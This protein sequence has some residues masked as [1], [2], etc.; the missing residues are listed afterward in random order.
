MVAT[1]LN[2]QHIFVDVSS[3]ETLAITAERLASVVKPGD[4]IALDGNLGA[5][6]TTF[7]QAFGD[8]LGIQEKIVSPTFVLIHEYELGPTPLIHI[9]LYRLG[10]E[11]ADSLADD[12]ATYQAEARSVICVEWAHLSQAL[13]PLVT[14]FISIAVEQLDA[15]EGTVNCCDNQAH[16]H[17]DASQETRMM[18]I[19]TTSEAVINAFQ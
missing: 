9:D 15:V 19:R 5:G 17:H 3:L 4:V 16:Q 13:Q 10:E 11:Q 6:K 7:V 14:H 8:A 12:I 1:S 2:Q 18:T